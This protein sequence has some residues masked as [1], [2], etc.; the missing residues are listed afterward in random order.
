M[1]VHI[2]Q[3][4]MRAKATFIKLVDFVHK[5]SCMSIV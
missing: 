5:V 4:K 2:E 3:A 1:T